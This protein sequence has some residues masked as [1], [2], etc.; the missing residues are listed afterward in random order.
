MP[1][2]SA[3]SRRRLIG[4]HPDLV[5]VC[6][7]A[8]ALTSV[9]FRIQEGVRSKAH[10]VSLVNAGASRT[11]DSRHI[12]GHAVDLVALVGARPRWDWPLYPILAKAMKAAAQAE[13]VPVVWGGCWR[14]LEGNQDLDACVAA[15][16]ARKRAN[17]EKPLMDGPHFE[18]L[19]SAYP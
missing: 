12:T 5:R 19:R 18:L 9:D 1:K 2:F 3:L 8:I 14:V 10:Q 6:E 13:H 16:V 11:I 4:V 7:R 17:G 15:Y